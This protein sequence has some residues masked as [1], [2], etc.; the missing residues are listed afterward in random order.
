[1]EVTGS[2]EQSRNA[3]E[4]CVL[5]QPL[6][7]VHTHTCCASSRRGNLPGAHSQ[8]ATFPGQMENA[9]PVRPSCAIPESR[10]YD[11]CRLLAK[12]SQSGSLRRRVRAITGHHTRNTSA[13]FADV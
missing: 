2:P 12:G 6:L 11:P 13:S 5:R 7:S 8:G 1:M 9:G 10:R 4:I 3:I